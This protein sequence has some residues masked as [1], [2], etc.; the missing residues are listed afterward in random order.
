MDK[1]PT[2]TQPYCGV[3]HLMI[4][5][6]QYTIS[7]YENFAQLQIYSWITHRLEKE[8]YFFNQSFNSKTCF[9]DK[10]RFWNCGSIENSI[11]WAKF[12]VE[13]REPYSML[14]C[15]DDMSRYIAFN[16]E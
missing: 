13:T 5:K 12:W 9:N 7:N 2:W 8:Y 10:N 6:V 11:Q 14:L 4:E 16:R 3:T 15:K 1:K